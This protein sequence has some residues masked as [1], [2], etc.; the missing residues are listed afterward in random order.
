MKDFEEACYEI[1]RNFLFQ[2]I[3]DNKIV[4]KFR[5]E[6]FTNNISTLIVSIPT[7]TNIV[8]T[9]YE[10]KIN[11]YKNIIIK[12]DLEIKNMKKQM[13]L[14]IENLQKEIEKLKKK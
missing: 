10:T 2:Y 12:K 1:A 6:I 8:N 14:K 13:E 5:D 7:I 4:N 9:K 3:S 11:N